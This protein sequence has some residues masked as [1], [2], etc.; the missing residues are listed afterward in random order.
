MLELGAGAEGWAEGEEGGDPAVGGGVESWV[1]GRQGQGKT[2]GG[3][4]LGRKGCFD[5]GMSNVQ[6][7]VVS[8]S[9]NMFPHS[10]F[11]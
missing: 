3:V 5:A 10:F 2:P 4:V 1:L 7:K 9:V 11:S 8:G 6:Y